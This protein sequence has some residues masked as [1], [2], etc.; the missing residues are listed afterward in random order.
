ML[1][2]IIVFGIILLFITLIIVGNIFV[3]IMDIISII[4]SGKTLDEHTEERQK[5][6]RIREHDELMKGGYFEKSNLLMKG[7]TS[8]FYRSH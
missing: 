8:S 4:T 2:I 5:L 6:V 1:L 7:N 3:F